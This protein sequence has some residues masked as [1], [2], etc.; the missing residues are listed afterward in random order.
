MK[1]RKEY[2]ILGI[3]IVVL[4]AY[5]LL[6][7]SDRSFY[8]LPVLQPV[9]TSDITRV[10]IDT[11]KENISLYRKGGK[12]VV[13]EQAFAADENQIKQA[14][15]IIGNLILTTLA[16]E[17]KNYERYELDDDHK[18]TVKAWSEDAL[19][20]DFEV[21]KSAPSFRHTFVKLAGDHRVY[22]ARENFRRVFEKTLDDLRDKTVLS[23]DKNQINRIRERLNVP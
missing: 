13:G 5:V 21:G 15:E 20:R 11:P 10:T 1:L 12:W 3:L 14:T 17:S 8:E 16:S 18:I 6:R 7:K 2:V 19:V 4:S 9:K 22:H 23:F